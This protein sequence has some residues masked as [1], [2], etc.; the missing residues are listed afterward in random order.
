MNQENELIRLIKSAENHLKEKEYGVSC[1]ESR[2]S[3]I[4]SLK[5]LADNL[6]IVINGSSL[7]EI[8]K[9]LNKVKELKEIKYCIDYLDSLKNLEISYCDTACSD[10]MPG[11]DVLDY[12][13]KDD[14][15]KAINCSKEIINLVLKINDDKI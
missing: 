3:A 14:A 13:N 7:R 12:A 5:L 4:Q 15:E 11:S 9:Q 10:E 8:Y 1:Y 2:L 6:K